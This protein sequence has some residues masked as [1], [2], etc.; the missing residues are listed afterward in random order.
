MTEE[1]FTELVNLYLDREISDRGIAEL[2]VELKENAERKLEFAE[3]CRLHQAMRL[4]LNPAVSKRPATS[5]GSRP[6]PGQTS[7]S[8]SRSRRQPIAA[9]IRGTG[10]SERVTSFP[11]WIMGTG[12]VACLAL[13]FTLL[14]PVFRDTTAVASQPA[15]DG[16]DADELIEQDPLDTIGRRELR[17]FATIQAQREASQRASIAA[18]LRLMGLRPEFTPKEKQLRTVSIAAARRPTPTRNDAKLLSEVQKLSPIPAQQILR[19]E[20]MEAEPATRWPG[21]FEPSLASF[22]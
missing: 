8:T 14:V 20:S 13:G 7:R 18:Q 22:K 4:A 11:R 9:P 21:G 5:K 10:T 6:S 15:L 3:R 16:V 1:K 12:L 19:I 17:R 2:K